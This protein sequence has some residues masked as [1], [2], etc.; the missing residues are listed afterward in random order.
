M[1]LRYGIKRIRVR[2]KRNG[3]LGETNG[4]KKRYTPEGKKGIQERHLRREE[5]KKLTDEIVQEHNLPKIHKVTQV[6]YGRQSVWAKRSR[7]A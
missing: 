5:R 3:Q 7:F 1:L 4:G 2:V 6:Q